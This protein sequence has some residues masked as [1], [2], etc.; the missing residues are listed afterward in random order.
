MK[1]PIEISSV[2]EAEADSAFLRLSQV[3]STTQA[4]QWYAGLLQAIESLSQFPKRCPL[5]RENKYFSQE[6]RQLLYGRGRNS[7]RILFTILEEQERATVR[8]LHIRHASQQT[9]GEELG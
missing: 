7:Y 6:I 9:L 8:I 4:S 1:Y 3:T 2:A 5:A